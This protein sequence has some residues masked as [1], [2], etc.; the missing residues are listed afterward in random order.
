M[1]ARVRAVA[2][3]MAKRA[4]ENAGE[5]VY[6]SELGR[7]AVTDLVFG[8]LVDEG[9]LESLEKV[10][11]PGKET[12]PA[13]RQDEAVVFIAFFDAGLRLPCVAL[14]LEVLRLYGVELA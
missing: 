4:K 1:L 3:T 7:S 10:R 5:A 9:K 12:I 13:P 14:T 6:T 2:S 11:A 8:T